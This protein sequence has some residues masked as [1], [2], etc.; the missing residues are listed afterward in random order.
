MIVDAFIGPFLWLFN[1]LLSL[2]PEYEFSFPG[3]GAMQQRIAEVNSVLPI[4]PILQAAVAV[5][6]FL[7]VFILFRLVLV[8]RHVL[9]P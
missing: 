4:G 8:I 3:M 5:L 2:L 9:L 6:G 7:V 1:S